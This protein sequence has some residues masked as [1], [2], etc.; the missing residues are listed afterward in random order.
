MLDIGHF[1]PLNDTSGHDAGDALLRELAGLLMARVREGD[2][3]CRY[4]GEEFVL[5]MPE[6]PLELT[7]RRAEELRRRCANSTC[8]TE[9]G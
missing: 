7:Q 2:I 4:G 5:I 6:A 3:A 9:V 8:R 1:K